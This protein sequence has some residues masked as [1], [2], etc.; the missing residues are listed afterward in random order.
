M[1][2]KIDILFCYWKSDIF[3]KKSI[4]QFLKTKYDNY[5][6]YIIDNT[7]KSKKKLKS[8]FDHPKI[9]IIKGASPFV[10]GKKKRIGYQ[11]GKHHPDGLEIVLGKTDSDYVALFHSDSWPINEFWIEKCL[12]YLNTNNVLLVG[13]QYESSIHSC[14]QFFKRETLKKLGYHFNIKKRAFKKDKISLKKYVK[15][16]E[17]VKAAR[18]KWDWG[19]DFSIKI[20]E[21][22]K[23]TIGL[24][25][26]KGFFPPNLIGNNNNKK[27]DAYWRRFGPDGYGIV[28]GDIIFHV[29]KTYRKHENLLQYKKYYEN[30]KYLDNYYYIDNQYNKIVINNGVHDNYCDMFHKKFIY[31]G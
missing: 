5:K 18:S 16:P 6:I 15:Y 29:W 3:I 22:N 28:Y 8:K 27:I 26:T 19:E 17:A 21:N 4:S 14:F 10:K 9:K 7:C 11:S 20:Y 25:P 31:H 30:D 13:A 12:E 1:A 23:N 24:N 2:E